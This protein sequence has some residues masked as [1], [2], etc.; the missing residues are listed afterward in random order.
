MLNTEYDRIAT[1]GYT[2]PL[3]VQFDRYGEFPSLACGLPDLPQVYSAF[4]LDGS[5]VASKFL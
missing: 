5:M 3:F 1:K 4:V 2:V